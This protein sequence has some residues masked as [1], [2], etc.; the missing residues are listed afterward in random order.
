MEDISQ[1]TEVIMQELPQ[2]GS[3]QFIIVEGSDEDI[4][5]DIL[6]SEAAIAAS[7]DDNLNANESAE[8]HA[9]VQERGGKSKNVF[10]EVFR[11]DVC[12]VDFESMNEL[13]SHANKI[14]LKLPEASPLP[15][16]VPIPKV[17][18]THLN[19]W[20]CVVIYHMQ[21]FC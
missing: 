3:L 6:K 14:H 10:R 11:C 16:S 17:R 13:Q 12:D 18:V 20:V 8:S 4:E 9:P 21:C 5:N 2:T 15:Q 19:R 7:S 1:A